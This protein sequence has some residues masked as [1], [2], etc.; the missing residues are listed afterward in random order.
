MSGLKKTK[1]GWA[2]E[3]LE[4]VIRCRTL[5]GDEHV[6]QVECAIEILQAYDVA[7]EDKQPTDS[8]I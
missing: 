7:N 4:K 8:C 3:D 6:R 2:I 1:L 5:L